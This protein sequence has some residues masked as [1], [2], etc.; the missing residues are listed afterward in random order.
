M[1][2]TVTPLP[3]F[4]AFLGFLRI[5]KF[6]PKLHGYSVTFPCKQLLSELI[7]KLMLPFLSQESD[8]SGSTREK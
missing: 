8:D 6:I 3:D 1:F 5:A 2:Y 7:I 4:S